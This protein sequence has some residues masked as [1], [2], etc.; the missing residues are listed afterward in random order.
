[1]PNPTD[2]CLGLGEIFLKHI[3]SGQANPWALT[4][5][6]SGAHTLGSATIANSG[7]DGF[8]SDSGA[9]GQFNNDYF[10]S[11]IAKGWTTQL[12]VNGVS[13]KN[14]WARADRGRTNNHKEM[15]LDTDICLAYRHT[16]DLNQGNA[17]GAFLL[18]G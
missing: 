11:M 6:I 7:F 15:M 13:G 1:M 10:K 17:S 2:G 8:W 14:Q 18:A 3:Y 16:E 5:A 9:Q 12:S 4:A